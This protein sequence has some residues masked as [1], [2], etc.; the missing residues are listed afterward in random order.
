MEDL[1]KVY[2]AVG[3]G[4][5]P[6]DLREWKDDD[7]K[8][9]LFLRL[10][11]PINSEKKEEL[12]LKSEGVGYGFFDLVI[13]A[14]YLLSGKR[15][16]F[17][18]GGKRSKKVQVCSEFVALVYWEIFAEPWKITT[19]DIVHHPAFRI[20]GEGEVLIT[21]DIAIE[22]TY[23]KPFKN[24]VSILSILVRLFTCSYWNHC[25]ILIVNP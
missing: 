18:K 14:I 12:I 23:F 11:E 25:G 9:Y 20:L 21:G 8:E 3:K 19:T 17:G 5:L 15:F 4:I 6:K 10:R 16:W 24:P 22:H 2:Q 1:I 13:Y 7:K